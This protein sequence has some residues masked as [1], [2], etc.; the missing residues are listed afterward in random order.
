MNILITGGAGFIGSHL[1]ESLV[2]SGHKVTVIDDLSSGYESNLCSVIDSIKFYKE[3]VEFFNFTKLSK[4]DSVVHL[5]AQTSVPISI[6]NFNNSSSS[7]LLGA[8]NIIDFC[9]SNQIPLVYASSAAV[10]GDLELGDD[11][12][13]KVDLLSPYAADKYAMELYA[14][15]AHQLY[16][17]SSIGLRFYNVYGPRQDPASAYSGVISIFCDRLLRGENLTIN[18]GYQTRDFIFVEDVVSVICK[19]VTIA[20]NQAICEQINT[21]TGKSISVDNV[22]DLL[23]KAVDIKV[24]KI[25]EDLP[26]GDPK[27]SN[28]TSSKI[29][30]ILKINLTEMTSIDKG[31]LITVNSLRS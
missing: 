20:N 3:K 27:R 31:L 15:V 7:N 19:S 9:K 18:G 29:Q 6:K 13:S 2:A 12:K 24:K 14:K 16:K 21:L 10:Y 8:I 5:A 30:T 26:A 28:G 23:I 11:S 17:L 25:F 4:I 22:A 1:C